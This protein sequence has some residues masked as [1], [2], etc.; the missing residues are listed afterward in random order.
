QLFLDFALEIGSANETVTVT[1]ETPQL[2]TATASIS[3][4][5]ERRFLDL[6]F[7]PGRNPL[8]LV[9]LAPGV[10]QNGNPVTTGSQQKQFAIN[11]GGGVTGAN[12]IV[13]DGGSVVMPRQ[14]GSM[15]NSPSGD[16]VEELR[17][18]T[19]MFD[20]AFG[21]SGGGVVTY[22]TRGGT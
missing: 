11:G 12:E 20:A 22:A 4:V 1:S 14:R 17:V 3:Q 8:N 19:T 5:V 21:H 15:A 6:L 13:I 10:S 7:I 2:E 9:S 16:T 18:Q